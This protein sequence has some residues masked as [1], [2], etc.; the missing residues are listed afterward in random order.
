[1]KKLTVTLLALVVMFLNL[2]CATAQTI[3]FDGEPISLSFT[4]AEGEPI[5]DVKT[6]SLTLLGLDEDESVA[7]YA[8]GN[9]FYV[10]R[11]DL[12]EVSNQ[13]LDIELP[14]LADL[15][16]IRRGSDREEVRIV[17]QQLIDLGYLTGDADGSFG[18]MSGN[19]VSAFQMAMGLEETGE[20]DAITRMLLAS[21]CEEEIVI[22]TFTDPAQQFKAIAD[23]TETDLSIFYDKGLT[24]EYDDITGNGFITNGAEVKAS[25]GNYDIDS[26]E[27]TL[28]F[29]F[30][31]TE[32]KGTVTIKPAVQ[33]TNISVRR[34]IMA[35]MFFKSGDLR[36]SIKVAGIT[37]TVEASKSVESGTV[38]LNADTSALLAQAAEAGELKMRIS[39]KYQSYDIEAPAE[40]LE[41]I[42]S[43]GAIAVALLGN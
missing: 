42:S 34:P 38:T 3:R 7:V 36:Q 39:G 31:V 21:M 30:A 4:D 35:T 15:E 27:F 1:M 14:K 12:E 28:R 40:M 19:A 10:T 41:S 2:Q 13:F 5:E 24:F 32:S 8:S 9:V 23:R 11:Q 20:A 43:I 33:I 16:T 37:N 29:G 25:E 6:D 26:Y 22:S 18:N 17:Q